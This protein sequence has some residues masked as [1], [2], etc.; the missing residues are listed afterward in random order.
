MSAI[1]AFAPGITSKPQK[2]TKMTSFV[3]CKEYRQN[4]SASFTI[5]ELL[6][7]IFITSL[8]ASIIYPI[9]FKFRERAR[10]YACASNIRQLDLAMAQYC[11]D[12]DDKLPGAYYG[13]YGAGDKRGGWIAY[14]AYPAN[15]GVAHFDVGLGTIYPYV[16]NLEVYICPDDPDGKFDH[17]SYAVNS[18]DLL[19][20]NKHGLYPGKPIADFTNFSDIMLL[21]EE[22][23]PAGRG[24]DDGFFRFKHDRAAVRHTGGSDIAFIDGHVK[25]YS[26]EK[27]AA[28]RFQSQT[29]NGTDCPQ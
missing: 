9:L 17:N 15:V 14:S 29:V 10:Q 27:L 18:C 11:Q 2:T 12:N 26:E 3:L 28:E 6:V 8:L 5:I 7:A 22:S 19:P 23:D 1:I 21:G 24:T 25:W 13:G 4:R 16:K 20:R